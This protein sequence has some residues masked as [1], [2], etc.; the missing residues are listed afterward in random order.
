MLIDA[1]PASVPAK[2]VQLIDLAP[3]LPEEIVTVPLPLLPSKNTSSAAVGMA[4]PPPPPEVVLHFVPAV[5]SHAAVP[6]TQKRFA[7]S[8][9][10]GTSGM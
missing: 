7:T 5:P 2:L 1:E 10:H 8:Q 3:V 4:E 6:P 9:P